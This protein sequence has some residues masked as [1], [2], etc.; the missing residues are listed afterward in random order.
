MRL[1]LDV[2]RL[3]QCPE[4]DRRRKCEGTVVSQRCNCTRNGT[5]MKLVEERRLVRSFRPPDAESAEPNADA[6]A[7]QNDPKQTDGEEP[8]VESIESPVSGP[9]DDENP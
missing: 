2:R 7:D 6:K 8:Q 3:W 9:P 4:C 5:W 1:D